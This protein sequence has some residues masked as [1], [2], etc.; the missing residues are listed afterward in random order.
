MPLERASRRDFSGL[1]K[2]ANP[3]DSIFRKMVKYYR[4]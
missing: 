1:T 3:Y 4:L 2:V